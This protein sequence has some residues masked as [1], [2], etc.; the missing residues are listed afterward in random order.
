VHQDNSHD[1]LGMIMSHDIENQKVSI[2]MRKYI[3]DCIQ[4][5]QE[6]GPD[7]TLNLVNIPAMNNLF[8]TRDAEKLSQRR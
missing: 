2:Y 8:R 6:V 3:C 4:E 7:K 5:F 1:Y